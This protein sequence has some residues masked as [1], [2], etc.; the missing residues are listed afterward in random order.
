MIKVKLSSFL[1]CI[2]CSFPTIFCI[3]RKGFHFSYILD[4]FSTCA[5]FETAFRCILLI[6]HPF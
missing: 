3:Q 4:F 5:P 2:P 6:L 1:V